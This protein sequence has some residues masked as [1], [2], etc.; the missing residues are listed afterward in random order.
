M[1]SRSLTGLR[2]T[3]LFTNVLPLVCRC[4]FI[5]HMGTR[6]TSSNS[7]MLKN[8]VHE[9]SFVATIRNFG[10]NDIARFKI[11]SIRAFIR[12]G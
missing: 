12:E 8:E 10:L 6:V 7:G 9:T 3:C 4:T 1:V 11:K 5:Q 2:L